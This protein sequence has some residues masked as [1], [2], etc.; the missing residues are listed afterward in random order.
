ML[1]VKGSPGSLPGWSSLGSNLMGV[2][3]P[4]QALAIRAV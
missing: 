4:H 2:V 3:K 1:V